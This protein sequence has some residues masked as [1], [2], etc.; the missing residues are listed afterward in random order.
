MSEEAK[1]LTKKLGLSR[2]GSAHKINSMLMNMSG[3]A[4]ENDLSSKRGDLTD[5][6]GDLNSKKGDLNGKKGPMK[7]T[8]VVT[9]TANLNGKVREDQ[10]EYVSLPV[11]AGG[12]VVRF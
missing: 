1:A 11:E 8:F 7:L 5:K 12:G 9:K 6:K 10:F 2:Y 3:K 4:G